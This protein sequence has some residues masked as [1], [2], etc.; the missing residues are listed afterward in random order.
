[1]CGKAALFFLTES[2]KQNWKIRQTIDSSLETGP[3]R[4]ASKVEA[5]RLKNRLA[6]APL[7]PSLWKTDLQNLQV[8][9]NHYFFPICKVV[10]FSFYSYTFLV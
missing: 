7:N 2:E 4:E 1:M 5:A 6:A 10:F 3:G 9:K 8:K